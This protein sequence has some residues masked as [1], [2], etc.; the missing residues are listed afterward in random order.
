M[1]GRIP[2]VISGGVLLAVLIQQ[3][4]TV[5]ASTWGIGLGASSGQAQA[6]GAPSAPTGVTATCTSGLSNTVKVSWSAVGQATTYS[7][8]ES[9]TSSISGF[10]SVATGVVGTSWTSPA[11]ASGNY[12]FE[13]TDYIGT[14]WIS[15]N[16]SAT[17]QRTILLVTCG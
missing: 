10:A 14:N 15:P 1:S 6:E 16:S 5:A 9:T 17:A 11:L 12:W 7:V 3:S 8:Y 13:I 2:L 4:A